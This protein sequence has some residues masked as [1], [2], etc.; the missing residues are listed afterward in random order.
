[1]AEKGRVIVKKFHLEYTIE[2][3]E[4]DGNGTRLH[5]NGLRVSDSMN[6]NHMG[7]MEIAQVLGR[8]HELAETV[9]K[10]RQI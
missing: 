1:V 2:I 8:F 6:L 5:G 4:V 3:V 10:E 9:Q 7:F